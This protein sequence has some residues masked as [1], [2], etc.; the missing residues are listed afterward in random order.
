MVWF[1][2]G[3]TVCALGFVGVFYWAALRDFINRLR[4]K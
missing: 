4:E 2:L 3:V 1:I